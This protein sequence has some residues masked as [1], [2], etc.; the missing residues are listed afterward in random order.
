MLGRP[1]SVLILSILYYY[2]LILLSYYKILSR[3]LSLEKIKTKSVVHT[4]KQT[5]MGNRHEGWGDDIHIEITHN[6]LT[7]R[8]TLTFIHKHDD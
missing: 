8:D 6:K 2:H 4:G 7:K 3:E 5:Q 1:G